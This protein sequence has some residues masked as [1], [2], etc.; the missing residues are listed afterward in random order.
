[1]KHIYHLLIVLS[2]LL[3]GILRLHAQPV[4]SINQGEAVDPEKNARFN[5]LLGVDDESFY[6]LRVKTKGR[7]TKYFVESY[8]KKSF[9]QTFSVDLR[10]DDIPGA[11]TDPRHF[12]VNSIAAAGKVY[13]FFRAYDRTTKERS[14][15]MKTIDKKGNVSSETEMAR[16]STEFHDE[17][18][19]MIVSSDRSKLALIS[20]V[21][22]RPQQVNI[23]IYDTRTFKPIREYQLPQGYKKSGIFAGS[24]IVH[25][26]GS[27]Y[28]S[29]NYLAA[30]EKVG[31]AL[32]CIPYNSNEMK[33]IE[34]DLS[35]KKDLY[36]G[37]VNFNKSDSTIT[38]AGIFKDEIE[39]NGKPND[40][41]KPE[42][43]A[44]F[45]SFKIN[46]T[47]F[48][49][50]KRSEKYFPNHIYDKLAY[51]T[52]SSNYP[53]DKF[54]TLDQILEV[55]D[56]RYLIAS[57]SYTVVSDNGSYNVSNELLVTKIN[58]SG[59]IEWMNIIPKFTNSGSVSFN[60]MVVNDKIHLLFL[61]HPKSTKA[62]PE[63]YEYNRDKFGTVSGVTG[64]N[65]ICVV[66]DENGK[67]EKVK[68]YEN[69][70][71]CYVPPAQDYLLDGDNGLLI[72][73]IRGDQEKFGS[74]T[75]K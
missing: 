1:M 8:D 64:P 74:I 50:V 19:Y 39:W 59:E 12:T 21:D 43:K 52:N 73:F 61:E 71:F 6:V 7:G 26:D 17:N 55:K 66:V 32:G 57:H 67:A 36:K 60:S 34:L 25:D 49:I 13:V 35:A 56:A 30:K 65:A 62:F 72:R 14:L 3:S 24:Y 45:F 10:L 37:L 51:Y 38:I 2:L 70:D 9:A 48:T 4:I 53:G 11:Q 15:M 46:A 41:N 31:L 44:G 54:Y 29:F 42:K 40:K 5:S 20:Q 27:L 69:K 68:F 28:F 16:H 22:S 75:I 23:T 33:A 58:Q 18:F 47:S 63:V